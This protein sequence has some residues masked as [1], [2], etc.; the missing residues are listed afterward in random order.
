MKTHRTAAGVA[1]AVLFLAIFSAGSAGAAKP[2]RLQ[3]TRIHSLGDSITTAFDSNFIADNPSESWANGFYGFWQRYFGLENVNSHNQR[4]DKAFRVRS[5]VNGGVNGAD[6]GNMQG[7][8]RLALA[9]TPYY[10]PIE[11]G[12]NDVCRD[13]LDDVPPPIDFVLDYLDGVAVLDPSIWGGRGGLTPGST[14]YTA[15]IPDI[16]QLYDVGKDE[17]GIFG[18]DCEAIWA[19]TLIGFPCGS[20]LS[21]LNTEQDR[22]ALQA[23]NLQYNQY[24]AYVT[25]LANA[26]SQRVYWDFT[27]SVWDYQVQ[28]SDISAIDCF[29]PSSEGQRR[30]S[31]GTLVDGPFAAF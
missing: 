12:G 23:I 16:K 22:L 18:I 5:N 9:T 29:H 19:T 21:P 17:T 6:M 25:A 8:A 24:L 26:S 7:Q 13:S 4:A 20:M 31:E 15:S 1:A 28:G 14:V 10:V 27:W 11:L 30:L 2:Q 3:P